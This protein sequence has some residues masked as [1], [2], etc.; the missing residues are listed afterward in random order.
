V[1][2]DSGDSELIER[3]LREHHVDTVMH[4]A[5]HTVVPESV[6]DPLKYYRNNTCCTRSL[7]ECCA[8]AGVRN[9]VFSSTAAVYGIPTDGVADEDSPTMPINPY[10]TSK[11]M[12]E[13]MLEIAAAAACARQ[14]AL[15]QRRR[16]SPLGRMGRTATPC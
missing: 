1:I 8:K 9:F 16:L 5:A 13:W 7:L 11:L 10:G 2:S 3:T 6:A 12:S 14:P 15:L 4:F